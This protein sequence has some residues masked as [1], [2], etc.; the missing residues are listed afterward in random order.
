MYDF[1]SW[2]IGEGDQKR[3]EMFGRKCLRILQR[4][5][6]RIDLKM[7]MSS[8]VVKKKK[9]GEKFNLKK[10]EVIGYIIKDNSSMITGHNNRWKALLEELLKG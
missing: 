9:L 7:R 3:I 1:K 6:G 8:K 2:N 4:I 5:R 10:K